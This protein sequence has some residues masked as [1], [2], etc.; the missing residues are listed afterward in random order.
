MESKHSCSA[1]LYSFHVGVKAQK[2]PQI[3]PTAFPVRWF[4]TRWGHE[5]RQDSPLSDIN[6]S[7]N[8]LTSSTGVRTF[9][10]QTLSLPPQTKPNTNY[11]SRKDTLVKAV[12]YPGAFSKCS[13]QML[14]AA[15][16][17]TP[18][19]RGTSSFPISQF[20]Q[21]THRRARFKY[22][23]KE[24]HYSGCWL[25]RGKEWLELKDKGRAGTYGN[26]QRLPERLTPNMRI[27][28]TGIVSNQY[29][30]AW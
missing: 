1:P 13:D 15:S 17:P 3:S 6:D 5:S 23:S 26:R 8:Y 25:G 2:S 18:P 7:D 22:L 10:T 14:P 19:A 9:S 30:S 20:I 27:T 21:L 12:C 29:G 11:H 16:T 4:V 28:I 24:Q